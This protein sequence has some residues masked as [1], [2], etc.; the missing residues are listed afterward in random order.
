MNTYYTQAKTLIKY[1]GDEFIHKKCLKF[2]L[3]AYCFSMFQD[4]LKF[5]KQNPKSITNL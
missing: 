1:L 5:L 2:G 4:P 3:D